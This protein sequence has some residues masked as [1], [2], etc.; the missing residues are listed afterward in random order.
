MQGWRYQLSLFANAVADDA[1]RSVPELV[2]RWFAAWSEPDA[3]K[4]NAALEDTVAA[5]VSMRDRFSSIEGAADLREHLAAIHHFMPGMTLARDGAVRQCQGMAHRRLGGAESGADGREQG[6][7]PTCST[8]T[9]RWPAGDG[10]GILEL[11][12]EVRGLRRFAKSLT[13]GQYPDPG[14]VVYLP[15]LNAISSC[16]V[17]DSLFALSSIR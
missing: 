7:A 15:T 17:P 6:E 4:R 8:F 11:S 16:A 5:D 9:R 14:P 3:A 10:D 2:D 12:R 1:D 13:L